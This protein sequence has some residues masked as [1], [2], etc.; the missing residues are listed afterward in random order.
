MTRTVFLGLQVTGPDVQKMFLVTVV[1]LMNLS[2][3]C[4]CSMSVTFSHS[5][6]NDFKTTFPC[7]P[8]NPV[9]NEQ[10]NRINNS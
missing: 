6:T 9:M 4:A 3:P 8:D 7:T 10:K 5:N 2:T 1:T